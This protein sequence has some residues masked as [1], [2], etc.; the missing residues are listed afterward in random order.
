[1]PRVPCRAA[2]GIPDEK[3]EKASGA[4]AGTASFSKRRNAQ[5]VNC[6]I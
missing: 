2:V 3:I 5:A 6:P 1:M 4:Y